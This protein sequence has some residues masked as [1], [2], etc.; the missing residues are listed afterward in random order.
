MPQEADTKNPPLGAG[1]LIFRALRAL[2]NPPFKQNDGNNSLRDN[3][4]IAHALS[5]YQIT[6]LRQ[7]SGG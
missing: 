5:I 4:L 1:S 2:A 7:E 3:I 6:S